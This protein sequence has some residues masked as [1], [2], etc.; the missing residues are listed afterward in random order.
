MMTTLN[1]DHTVHYIND[2]ETAIKTFKD[3]KLVA[4][5]GGSH[6]KW[7]TY[8]AL[9]YFGLTYIEFLGIEDQNLAEKSIGVNCVVKDAVTLLPERETMLRIAIRTDD[10]DATAASLKEQGL[11]LSAIIDG[12]R[13][14]KRGQLIEWRMMTIEENFQDL[15]YPFIIQWKG[16][17]S[18]RLESLT[19]FG[20]ITPHPAGD[21]T[22][23][24]AVFFVSDPI[25]TAA[26]WQSLFNLSIE[27]SDET[28]VI[29]GIGDKSFIFKKGNDNQL[30]QLI[31][32]T[33]VQE[34]KGK[35]I[36]IGDGEYLFDAQETQKKVII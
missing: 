12:S 5:K 30:K 34:L 15:V 22:L 18:E 33:E 21:V 24:S 3:N 13:L 7:G 29:L 19:D 6:K 9:S 25:I 4:F 31:F 36:S 2:L 1:W 32:K 23:E 11:T 27:E 16:T 35:I 10:I 8:N 20:V 17:D 14:D 28:S 26:H